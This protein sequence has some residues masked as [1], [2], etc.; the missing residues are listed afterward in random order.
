MTFMDDTDRRILDALQ[1]DATLSN[2]ALAAKVH[3][4]PATCLRRVKGLWE[5]G[6]IESQVAVVNPEKLA[7]AIGHGLS[8][9]VEVSLERQAAEHL[10]AFEARMTNVA[11]VQQ[12]YRVSPGPDFVLVLYA[13]NMADYQ[14]ISQQLFTLD[15][16]VRNVKAFFSIRRS[17]FGSK[18]QVL[19]RGPA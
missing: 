7:T 10:S 2:L 15:A 6:L 17:K 18:I 1:S 13:Q 3:V 16:N 11:A 8:V 14:N 9:I 19:P 5:E 12:C 4:S